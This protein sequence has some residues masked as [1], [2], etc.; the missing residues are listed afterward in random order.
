MS[1]SNRKFMRGE[2]YYVHSFPT[3]GH[4][5]RSGRPAVIVSNNENNA[6]SGVV[7]I[8]YLTLQEKTP[9]P[10]HIFIDRGPCINSTVLCEQITSVSTDRIGDYMCRIPEHLE[11]ALDKAL[12]A[13]L[14]L[15]PTVK[16]D[17]KTASAYRATPEVVMA[18]LTAL[19]HDSARLME[20]LRLAKDANAT[21]KEKLLASQASLEVA[22]ARADMYERMYNDILDKLVSRGAR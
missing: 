10:T 6:H 8:C 4:E 7:E 22:N 3:C 1:T 19:K 18:E 9:L 5:Q 16:V 11:E 17:P 2:I 20:E 21:I 14:S 15:L 13:S 12:M